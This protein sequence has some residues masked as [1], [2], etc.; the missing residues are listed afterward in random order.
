M[1]SDITEFN[2][3]DM[4]FRSINIITKSKSFLDISKN[5]E[6]VSNDVLDIKETA[7]KRSVIR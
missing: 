2:L 7:E 6:Q 4:L 1:S 3:K 5:L